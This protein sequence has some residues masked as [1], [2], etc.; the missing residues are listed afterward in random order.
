MIWN[1][2]SYTVVSRSWIEKHPVLLNTPIILAW[3]ARFPLRDALIV[4]SMNPIPERTSGIYMWGFDA[5]DLEIIWYVGESIDIRGRLCTHH[6]HLRQGVNQ[7]PKGF[8]NGSFQGLE[9]V[10]SGWEC[11]RKDPLVLDCL[12]N[13]QEMDKIKKAGDTFANQAFARF[14]LIA[15]KTKEELRAIEHAATYNLR[16]LVVK[17]Y[18]SAPNHLE[19]TNVPSPTEQDWQQGWRDIYKALV[20]HRIA[21]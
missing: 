5:N 4:G 15:S 2:S 16:P 10:A 19:I 21:T 14:A 9:D 3:S 6:R 11:N 8:L 17:K 12:R 7:I 13:R 20:K 18:K 1:H